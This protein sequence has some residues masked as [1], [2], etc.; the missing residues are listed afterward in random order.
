MNKACDEGFGQA[1]YNLSNV[2]YRGIPD[3]NI[4]KN[5]PKIFEYTYKACE[6]SHIN[7]CA[8][9]SLMYL[10]GEGVE[11]N[12]E[13]GKK[14]QK[15]AKELHDQFYKEGIKFEEGLS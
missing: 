14:Y 6:H 1:C 7:A 11:K 4:G 8:N 13:L 12:I 3:I 15:K 5:L 2:Y 10:K 9:L